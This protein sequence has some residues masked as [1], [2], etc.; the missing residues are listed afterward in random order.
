MNFSAL[1]GQEIGVLIPKIHQ[2]II[3]RVKL[4]GVESGGIW[5]ESQDATNAI[6][7]R[8]NVA[9]APKTPVFFLP[10]HEIAF[11]IAGLDKVS[12]D[13]KSFGL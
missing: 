9:T 2:T 4:I 13:E 10:Y 12:L 7:K 5:V 8:F 11:A 3:Q 1:I 6:L